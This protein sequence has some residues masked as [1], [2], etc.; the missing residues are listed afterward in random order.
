M[1]VLKL[2]LEI[3]YLILPATVFIGGLIYRKI[4]HQPF[5]VRFRLSASCGT[6]RAALR[7]SIRRRR[8]QMKIR[9]A[10]GADP[11]EIEKIGIAGYVLNGT[12]DVQ[13]EIPFFEKNPE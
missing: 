12:S 1:R 11:D 8:M 6:S 4:T 10:K 5:K 9:K 13:P 3:W 7:A 2:I